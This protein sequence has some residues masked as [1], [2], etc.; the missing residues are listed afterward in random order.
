M[1]HAIA[2]PPARRRTGAPR[3]ARRPVAALLGA[4][5]LLAAPFASA[6][7]D[8]RAKALLDGITPPGEIALHS[9][10]QTMVLTSYLPDGTVQN[11][12]TTRT[13][14]DYDNRR[15]AI[16]SDIGQG[17]V[18]TMRFVD[19]KASMSMTGVPMALPVPPEMAKTFETIFDPPSAQ[20]EVGPGDTL[21]FDGPQSYGD[22]VSGDQV[23]LTYA[24]D[25]GGVLA[26]TVSHYLFDGSGRL[27]GVVSEIPDLPMTLSVYEQPLDAST[28]AG[29]NATVYELKGDA[30]VLSMSMTFEEWLVDE[31]LDESI[32]E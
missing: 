27:V 18:S 4:T 25:R 1:T 15:A 13:V 31:P 28:V 26:G 5:M 10:Q 14:V 11:T 8:A 29:A 32:F 23:T 6:Q 17:M 19:G 2:T 3:R 12:T 22:V 7:V 20:F 21:T 9:L 24:S 30:W 16:V